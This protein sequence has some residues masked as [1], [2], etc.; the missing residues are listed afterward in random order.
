MD[1]EERRESKKQPLKRPTRVDM[2]KTVVVD[3]FNLPGDPD[4]WIVT[5]RTMEGYREVIDWYVTCISTRISVNLFDIIYINSQGTQLY[6]DRG[7]LLLFHL[8]ANGDV[9]PCILCQ[10]QA[11]FENL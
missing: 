9:P 2:V 6:L 8:D 10:I 5:L 7:P 1:R 11:S 4:H 3:L